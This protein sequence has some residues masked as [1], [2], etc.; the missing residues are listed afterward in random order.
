M[1]RF[2]QRLNAE[3][4]KKLVNVD[5]FLKLNLDA[6][7]RLLPP[8]SINKVVN[9]D[10]RFNEE[11]QKGSFYRIL[12][13]INSTSTNA[14]FNLADGQMADE[15]T[16]AGFNY[17]NAENEFRFLDSIYPNV[18]SKYLKEKDGWFGYFE[19][20]L[21]K[22]DF[23]NFYDMEPKRERFS[24]ISDI[25]PFHALDNLPIKNWELTITYPVSVDSGH[26]M[27]NN[28]LMIIDSSQADVSNRP[29]TAIG[30]GCFHNLNIGDIVN[31]SGTNGYDGEHVVIRTGLDNGDLKAY[32]FVI[33][34]PPMGSVSFNSR[35]KR[36]FGGIESIYYFRK[37]RKIKTRNS[38]FIKEGDYESYKLAF[39]E[40]YFSDVI[41]QFSFNEDIDISELVDNLGRPL[42]ELYLTIIKTDSNNLFSNV[43]SGIETPFIPILNT[44]D[45]NIY[46]V[47]IP[48]INR[49]HNGGAS[50]FQ[51]HNPLENDVTISGGITN[52][53]EFYGDLV[54]YNSNEV[55]ETILADVSHRF[56]TVNRETPSQVIT[57]NVTNGTNGVAPTLQTINLGA[58]QEGYIY[59]PH[60]LIKIREL[61]SYVEQGDQFTVGIP[62]YAI[63]LNDGRFLWRDMLDIGFNQTDEFPLDYP[64]LN[65]CHYMYDNYCFTVRRQDPFNNWDLYYSKFPA[66]PIGERTTNKF[67]FNSAEDV[68]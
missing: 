44:S 46:L 24:F 59:K 64:F 21:N 53:N 63:D 18:V 55:K 52:S 60:H 28:G 26:T 6:K 36:T 41:S 19:P 65:G 43:S 9:A 57:Y 12:G 58:R 7:Q 62:N 54:E 48:V 42:S 37:F 16:W 61:S 11:R 51:S 15:F 50:P 38:Q 49:I 33:D 29:M 10:E 47:D 1:E 34:V 14:L 2:I 45:F 68:C 39:S 8:S 40:N 13:T 67:D 31:I 5:T 30:M 56:N 32:Y 3:T 20:D 22:A 66:D 4:S 27:V 23:C 35:M 25:S 17:S